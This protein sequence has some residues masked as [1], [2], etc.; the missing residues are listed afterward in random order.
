MNTD[1]ISR[2]QSDTE[3]ETRKQEYLVVYPSTPK[4]LFL[5]LLLIFTLF[6][7]QAI[8]KL[9]LPGIVLDVGANQAG[10]RFPSVVLMSPCACF[11]APVV[12]TRCDHVRCSY[13]S[14]LNRVPVIA[15]EALPH[16]VE[17]MKSRINKYQ[18]ESLMR[19][20]HGAV[21]EES[22]LDVQFQNQVGLH[23]VRF[24]F[25]RRCE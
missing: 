15:F 12:L 22:G 5:C 11:R 8:F 18:L 13:A 2:G 16:N 25:R 21:W 7:L 24:Q 9:G 19:V 14:V 17:L 4:F 20:V 23:S 10:T 1:T 3:N 6:F